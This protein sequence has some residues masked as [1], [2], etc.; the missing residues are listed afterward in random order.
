MNATYRLQTLR[1]ISLLIVLLL[2]GVTTLL[3][4]VPAAPY[5]GVSVVTPPGTPTSTIRLAWKVDPAVGI[6]TTGYRIYL[7]K[8]VNPDGTIGDFQ[9]IATTTEMFY[10]LTN[11]SG[12]IYY[13]FYVTAYN[14]DG[15]SAPSNQVRASLDG[16]PTDPPALVAFLSTPPRDVALGSTYRYQARAVAQD[17]GKVRYAMTQ[18]P[19]GAPIPDAVGITVDRETG[20]VEWTPN[21]QG[22]YAAAVVAYLAS[23]TVKSAMQVL[24][25]SVKEPACGMIYGSVSDAKGVVV[26]N[27]WVTALSFDAAGGPDWNTSASAEV[28]GGEYSLDVPKGTYVVYLKDPQVGAIWYK[29]GRD[30]AD[31]D[32]ITVACGDRVQADFILTLPP[33]PTKYVIAGRVTN[34]ENGLG[35]VATLHFQTRTGTGRPLDPKSGVVYPGSISTTTDPDGRYSIELSDEFSYIAEAIPSNDELLSQYYDNVSNPTEATLITAKSAGSP[36]DFALRTRPVYPNNISGSVMDATGIAVASQV[37]AIRFGGGNAA[38]DPV[39]NKEFAR[40]ASTLDD[41]TFTMNNLVPGSYVLLAIPN[42][43]DHIPGY[44]LSGGTATRSWKEATVITVG[45]MTTSDGNVITLDVFNGGKGF[46]KFGGYVTVA[47]G[48]SLSGPEPSGSSAG[49]DPLPG[50]F[51]YALDSNNSV[52]DYTFS[53]PSGWFELTELAAI[54][55][56]IVADKVGYIAEVINT[57]LDYNGQPKVGEGI[58]MGRSTSSVAPAT[59]Q[60]STLL[61]YPNPAISHLQLRFDAEAGRASLR[62]YN[63]LGQ[64]VYTKNIDVVDGQNS[65][66]VDVSTFGGGCYRVQLVGTQVETSVGFVVGGC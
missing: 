3:A 51:V 59:T 36:V 40:S 42:L 30:I 23:D 18:S 17:G 39:I 15:E 60:S 24:I 52:D 8:S 48:G 10:E 41:G 25:I 12:Q 13:V 31:A 26:S 43:R 20:I 19:L 5:L 16:N 14:N 49:S 61:V 57:K 53:D 7:A 64:R 58:K 55:Y 21:A 47:P 4:G 2:A 38:G 37:I 6:P 27:G 32:R 44:F 65:V 50:T 63:S 54:N 35:V 45:E 22:T 28:I 66:E 1:R 62:I 11:V 34:Q 9:E 29:N 46:A 33:Q 56:R